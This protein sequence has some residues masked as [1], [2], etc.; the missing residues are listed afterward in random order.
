MERGG[1]LGAIYGIPLWD[2]ET[3]TQ[4]TIERTA[5]NE[6]AIRRA[7]ELAGGKEISNKRPNERY[8]RAEVI[9]AL[10]ASAGVKSRAARRLGCSLSTVKNYVDRYAEVRKALCVIREEIN[11]V[12]ESVILQAL[13]DN[14]LTAAIF[15]LK[16]HGQ[17]RGYSEKRTF[18]ESISKPR[19]P[20][21][22]WKA[23]PPDLLRQVH[24]ALRASRSA[25]CP[26]A[27][28]LLSPVLP[29][30]NPQ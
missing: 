8:S 21:F 20:D 18:A 12:A 16:T 28:R 11:D 17:D 5:R 9:A 23:L 26:P 3:M 2:T 30:E 7:I 29:P 1:P 10:D 27:E 24:A 6:E 14:S 13:R 25:D 15:Y 4:I 22:D 19:E